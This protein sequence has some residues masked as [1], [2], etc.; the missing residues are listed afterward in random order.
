[1]SENLHGYLPISN[2]LTYL[3]DDGLFIKICNHSEVN[4]RVKADDI[5]VW[6]K[7]LKSA[8]KP[9]KRKLYGRERLSY[10]TLF[11]AIY[12]CSSIESKVRIRIPLSC[13]IDFLGFRAIVIAVPPIDPDKGLSLGFNS[14]G[15]FENIDY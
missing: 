11:E 5:A 13:Q 12:I 3:T 14:E 4:P 7:A 9:L 10:D 1:M 15:H 2:S 8:A 6:Q